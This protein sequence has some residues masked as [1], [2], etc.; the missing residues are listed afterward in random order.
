[1]SYP[2]RQRAVSGKA[3]GSATRQVSPYTV[4]PTTET[5]QG[6]GDRQQHPGDHGAQMALG[7]RRQAA[8]R[9]SALVPTHRQPSMRWTLPA[10][11]GAAEG[12]GVNRANLAAIGG[13]SVSRFSVTPAIGGRFDLA[14]QGWPGVSVTLARR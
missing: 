13:R 2:A 6:A 12:M 4:R 5:T 9:V 3:T 11:T 7:E 14:D 8:N 1:V 10:P